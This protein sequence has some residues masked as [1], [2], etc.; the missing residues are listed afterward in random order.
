MLALFCAASAYTAPL[1]APARPAVSRAATPVL[2]G[3]VIPSKPTKGYGYSGS[4]K[5]CEPSD[6]FYALPPSDALCAALHQDILFDPYGEFG[7]PQPTLSKKQPVKILSRVEELKVLSSLA[8][9]G[10]L[11]SLESSGTFSKLERAGAFSAAEKLLPLADDLKL[12][13]VANALLNL[14]AFYLT[15]GAGVIVAGGASR[16]SFFPPS[17]RARGD[18]VP[19]A[20]IGAKPLTPSLSLISQRSALSRSCRTASCLIPSRLAPRLSLACHR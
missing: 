4:G 11:S 2:S 15:V 10:L 17:P 19:A 16:P 3:G 9:T 12:L 7:G 13:S 20:A 1:A 5:V 18:R 6:L 8:D 14:P